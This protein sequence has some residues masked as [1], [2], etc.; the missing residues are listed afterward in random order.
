MK[1]L[2]LCRSFIY[3]TLII[4][5]HIISDNRKWQKIAMTIISLDYCL[6]WNSFIHPYHKSLPGTHY[7]P[8]TALGTEVT[9][10]TETCPNPQLYPY[11]QF[12]SVAQLC[13]TVCDPMNRSTP[14]LPVHHQLPEY[15]SLN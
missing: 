6:D 10:D 1:C 12:S 2:L 8:D 11:L 13:P 7:S 9:A 5:L 4:K 14:A 3:F 15:V